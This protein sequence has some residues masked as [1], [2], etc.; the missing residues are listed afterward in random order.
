MPWRALILG[1]VSSVTKM[2]STALSSVYVHLTT[3][4]RNDIEAPERD[5]DVPATDVFQ[6]VSGDKK[7]PESRYRKRKATLSSTV[8]LDAVQGDPQRE[9]MR[10][11]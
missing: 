10:Q 5:R 6:S 7:T 4:Q 1:R 8:F 11:I 3:A 2:S 9:S